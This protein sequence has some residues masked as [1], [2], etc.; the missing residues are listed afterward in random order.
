MNSIRKL[1]ETLHKRNSENDYSGILRQI[2]SPPEELRPIVTLDS[3]RTREL[4]PMLKAR[5]SFAGEW[6]NAAASQ[7][8]LS[9]QQISVVSSC[10]QIMQQI[11]LRI[12]NWPTSLLSTTPPDSVALFGIDE[13]EGEE[14]YLVWHEGIEP[15]IVTYIGN[16]ERAYPDFK[17]YL[18]FLTK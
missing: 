14:T 13:D 6:Q 2:T 5:F 3:A 17:E 8:W 1:L 11:S 7:R 12:N 18:L 4:S 16:E 15:I 9:L 10:Q